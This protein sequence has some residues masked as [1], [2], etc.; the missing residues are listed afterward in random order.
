MSMLP[1]H[2]GAFRPGQPNG[3]RG[4]AAGQ[5]GG[6]THAAG[7]CT[8]DFSSTPPC[9]THNFAPLQVGCSA[10]MSCILAP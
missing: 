6:I 9:L 10:G 8:H 4:R 2:E 1:N 5:G 3:A 7:R